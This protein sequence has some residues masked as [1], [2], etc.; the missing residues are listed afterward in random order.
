MPAD[1]HPSPRPPT[2]RT[3]AADSQGKTRSG[4]GGGKYVAVLAP[5]SAYGVRNWPL[6][7]WVELEDAL[8]A[9]G[10]ATAILDA[11]GDGR[12]T[13]MFRG[14]RYWGQKPGRVAA[15]VGGADIVAG[16]DSGICHLAGVLGVPAVAVCG[17]TDGEAIFGW[18]GCVR[19]IQAPADCSPCYWLAARGYKRAC[20]HGCDA[21]W[22]IRPESVLAA[23][24]AVASRAGQ[25]AIRNRGRKDA[26]AA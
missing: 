7:R 17:P 10:F 11:P 19:N 26:A 12:R 14:A 21:L 1:R 16:N 22:A 25:T 23:A 24:V 4:S 15:I 2:E 6:H 13:A 20:V 5:Y 3:A 9:S 8:L 18:Y